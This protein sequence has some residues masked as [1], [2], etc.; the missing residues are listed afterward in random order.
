MKRLREEVNYLIDRIEDEELKVKTREV[1]FSPKEEFL[2]IRAGGF[3]L[4]TAPASRRA[5]H[6]YL[7]GLLEHTIAST[8]IAL[9]L[10]EVVERIYGGSVDRDTV[11]AGII[12][13]DYMK[14]PLYT[15]NDKGEIILSRLGE[16]IDHISMA[17]ADMVERGFPAHI[18]HTV[19]AHH[20][21]HG[22][23]TPKTV[24]ALIVHLADYIDSALNGRILSAAGFIVKH[25]SDVELK[26]MDIRTALRI[27]STYTRDGCRE[28]KEYISTLTPPEEG[29]TSPE[30]E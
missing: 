30:N 6:S 20:G 3:D 24:E 14:T 5:H 23:I 17:V 12:L 4:L 2:G 7:T 18:I 16:R 8:K 29:E 28:V 27:L 13:H 21:E 19:A 1:F 9:S 15:E 22:I 11:L 26:G 10:V 25:C